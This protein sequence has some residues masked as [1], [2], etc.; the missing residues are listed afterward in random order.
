M[1]RPLDVLE[2]LH[3]RRYWSRIEVGLKDNQKLYRI[4]SNLVSYLQTRKK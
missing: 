4:P 3:F 1:V 2:K